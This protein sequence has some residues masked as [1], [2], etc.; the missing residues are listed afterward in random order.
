MLP[1]ELSWRG[2]RTRG[3]AGHLLE[4]ECRYDDI[5]IERNLPSKCQSVNPIELEKEMQGR[6][7]ET[8]GRIRNCR[9][10]VNKNI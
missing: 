3:L 6:E 4:L 1:A 5:A 7:E 8:G 10:F 2:N 9:Q